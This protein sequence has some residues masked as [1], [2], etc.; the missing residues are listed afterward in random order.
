MTPSPLPR[1]ISKPAKISEVAKYAGVSPG[2]VSNVL[3]HPHRVA[4][5]TRRKVEEAIA[6]LSY[7]RNSP[8]RTLRSGNSD[9]TAMLL[10]APSTEYITETFFGA[11]DEAAEF[12]LS[13]ILLSFPEDLDRQ[14]RSMR[15]LSEQYISGVLVPPISFTGTSFLWWLRQ[16]NIKWVSLAQL[17]TPYLSACSVSTDDK[18]GGLEVG[19]HLLR[20]GH[21]RLLFLTDRTAQDEPQL[22]GLQQA[23][24]EAGVDPDTT[25]QVIRLPHATAEEGERAACGVLA[26]RVS[27]VSCLNDE[28]A[29]G[30]VNGLH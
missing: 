20:N 19:R 24:R 2:T 6:K 4:T 27:A 26:S 16:R 23:C 14:R 17:C 8:G 1:M 29:M 25:V 12:S 18:A 15:T 10:P 13:M 5:N 7:V 22:T 11:E 3:N 30:L 9:L 28:L 21:E